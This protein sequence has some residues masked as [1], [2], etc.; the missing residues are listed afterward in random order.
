MIAVIALLVFV[1]KDIYTT[2]EHVSAILLMLVTF[3]LHHGWGNYDPW[4]LL[5]PKLQ[6]AFEENLS[7]NAWLMVHIKFF[8][9]YCIQLIS[10]Y[11]PEL[12]LHGLVAYCSMLYIQSSLLLG[13]IWQGVSHSSLGVTISTKKFYSNKKTFLTHSAFL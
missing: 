3:G 11:K 6:T 1:C 9:I 10:A 12:C 2:F 5:L 7:C 4:Q 8:F 13:S